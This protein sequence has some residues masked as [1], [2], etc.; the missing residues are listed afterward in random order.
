MK[1]FLD[2]H[3]AVAM[4]QG[5][6][7]DFGAA[8][9]DLFERA[10]LF[11]SP[12]VRLELAFL[13]EIARITVGADELLGA[14]STDYGVTPSRDEIS[15]VVS[16]SLALSWTRDPFDRLIVATAQLHRAPLITKDERIQANYRDAVW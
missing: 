10:A 15:D 7:G 3:A 6:P 5:D 14:L 4:C 13:H 12:I 8:A 1:A 11:Y 16:A 2:T 9:L